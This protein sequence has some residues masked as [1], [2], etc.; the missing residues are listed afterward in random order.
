[1]VEK[2]SSGSRVTFGVV[3]AHSLS[4]IKDAVSLFQENNPRYSVTEETMVGMINAGNGFVLMYRGGV[5]IG[6]TW[7]TYLPRKNGRVWLGTLEFYITPLQRG[8]NLLPR[9]KSFLGVL[10]R[11]RGITMIHQ[12]THSRL[13]IRKAINMQRRRERLREKFPNLEP[14]VSFRGGSK[15][16]VFRDYFVRVRPK[17]RRTG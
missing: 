9:M 2:V 16:G 13:M 10:V 11:R 6:Y 3:D 12:M 4:R 8:N 5:P 7:I 17:R 1:M 15:A 14:A